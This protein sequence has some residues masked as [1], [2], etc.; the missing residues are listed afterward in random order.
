MKSFGTRDVGAIS[1]PSEDKD[2][3]GVDSILGMKY[4]LRY[5]Q[6]TSSRKVVSSK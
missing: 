3:S 2:T 5:R 6:F 1:R 4:M